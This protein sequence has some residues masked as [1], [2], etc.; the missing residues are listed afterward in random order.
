MTPPVKQ[1]IVEELKDKLGKKEVF[2]LVDCRE[3]DEHKKASISGAI[4]IPLSRFQELAPLQLDPADE[5]VIHC[6][7]GG[8]SQRACEYLV[9][10]G[11]KNVSNLSGGIDAWSVKIDPKTPRYWG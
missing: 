2:K 6:H 5:I 1:I 10:I 7:F 9:N 11:Y 8:R 3:K 4:L